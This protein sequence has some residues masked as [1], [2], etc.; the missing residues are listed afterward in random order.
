VL[1]YADI[2]HGSD[3][4]QLGEGIARFTVGVGL[5]P[6]AIIGLVG[7]YILLKLFKR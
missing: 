6:V 5:I 3:G 2:R 1:A 7:A 4:L